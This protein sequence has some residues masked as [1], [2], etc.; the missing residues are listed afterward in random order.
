MASWLQVVIGVVAHVMAI[1]LLLGAVWMGFVVPLKALSR[2][3]EN[4]VIDAA[5]AWKLSLESSESSKAEEWSWI[6]LLELHIV[7]IKIERA[8]EKGCREVT[9]KYS[10]RYKVVEK[11]KEKGYKVIIQ[12]IDN[13][14]F[15]TV[16]EW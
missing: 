12:T 7:D 6:E 9:L 13:K 8:C 4:E 16:I 5:K 14:P 10:L 11:L 2:N 3:A 1:V 15:G